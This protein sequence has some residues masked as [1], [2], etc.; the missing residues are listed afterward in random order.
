[1]AGNPKNNKKQKTGNQ[2]AK[3]PNQE[4]ETRTGKELE[5][6]E[7]PGGTEPAEPELW[8]QQSRTHTLE[9]FLFSEKIT[10]KF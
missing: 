2:R 3:E 7:P 10:T 4:P 5:L 1:M 6:V 8:C 9:T